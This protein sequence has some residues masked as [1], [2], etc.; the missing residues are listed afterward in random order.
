MSPDGG[1]GKIRVLPVEVVG[2]IAAGEVIERPAAVVK[3]LLDNSLDAGSSTITVEVSNGGLG[4]IRVT[5]DGEGMSRADAPLAF[6]RHATS[7]LRSDQDLWSVRTMGFRGEALPSIAAVSKVRLLTS[8]RDEPVGTQVSVVG[9]AVT[10]IE[11]A[12]VAHGTRVEVTDLFFNTP[13]RKKFL[14][15]PATEFAHISQ[16]VQQ[17]GLAW[18]SVHFRLFHN[19]REVLNLPAVS[20]V[21][22][23]VLQ[24]Y[25]LSFLDRT[26][27]VRGQWPGLRIG[28]FAIQP[29]HARASRTPQDLFVNRRPVRNATVFHAIADGYAS[30]LAKGRYPV[31]VLFLDVDA[32]RVDVN[33]HPTKREIRFVDQETVHHAVR[34]A[35][36]EALGAAPR[37]VPVAGVQFSG[38][39]GGESAPKQ[40]TAAGSNQSALRPPDI[41]SGPR[42]DMVIATPRT[43]IRDVSG[44]ETLQTSFVHE[45]GQ[46]YEAAALEVLPL[47]QINRT[48]LVAQVGSELQVVDQHTAHERILFER[49]WRAWQSRAVQSQP[50]LLP[51]PIDVPPDKAILLERHLGDF[52][53]LGLAIEPFGSGTF[54]VRAVPTLLGRLDAASLIQDVIDELAQWESLSALEAK[55][56]PIIAT[57][58]CHGAVRA[59][60]AMNLPE[61]KQLIEDWIKEGLI[62]TCPH[63]RRVALR[64]PAEELAK[65]FGRA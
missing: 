21:R 65:I 29:V 13:A 25:R 41:W 46:P 50:L 59:G 60:R 32:S 26:V 9:G 64:L 54:I 55:L 6:Q 58:A 35:V 20:S 47:G 8:S 49:L 11:D 45:P 3:E 48:F 14:K 1:V 38:G 27:E 30:F 56:R 62:M 44:S 28:G 24:I 12:A 42:S 5:D 4:L 33:V 40:S 7:K 34:Q 43:A 23:R 61:M 10:G 57:L 15:S 63:G 52:E 18:P 16:T 39:S 17:A 19:G 51:E 31:F 53:Q 22:D 37:V 36:R 2:R